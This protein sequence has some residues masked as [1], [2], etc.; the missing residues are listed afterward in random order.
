MV[1]MLIWNQSKIFLKKNFQDSKSI[2]FI[3]VMENIR[4]IE[5]YKYS[6]FYSSGFE[7]IKLIVILNSGKI[8]ELTCYCDPNNH[9]LVK[10]N[11]KY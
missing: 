5:S 2:E 1:Y 8:E 10:L 3:E 11:L 9:N 6:Y 7:F 4:Q